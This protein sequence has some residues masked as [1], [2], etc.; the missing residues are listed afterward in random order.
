MK[1]AIVGSR[2]FSDYEILE[3][4]ICS[5]FKPEDIE[6]VIS[7]GAVGTDTLAKQFANKY[8]INLMELL[9][10]WNKYGKRAGYIRN[11]DIIGSA[12]YVYIFWDGSSPGT[13]QDISLCKKLSKQ[14]TVFMLN[15]IY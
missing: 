2:S 3:R 7:G 12:D 5:H 4:E 11:I 8:Q 10:D 13:K 1:L 15:M 9:P 14:Y 6:L